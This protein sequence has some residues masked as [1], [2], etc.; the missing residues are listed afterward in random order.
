MK[1]TFEYTPSNELVKSAIDKSIS[2]NSQLYV[3][4]SRKGIDASTGCINITSV[5]GDVLDMHECVDN[6][7][8]Y[9]VEINV[10][11]PCFIEIIS[12]VDVGLYLGINRSCHDVASSIAFYFGVKND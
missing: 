2:D 1:I 7:G 3:L 4:S 6:L 11:D 10:F 9:K 8:T 12:T 5:V